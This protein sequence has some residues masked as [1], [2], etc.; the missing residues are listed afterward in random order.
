MARQKCHFPYEII[1]VDDDS[2]DKTVER[3]LAFVENAAL[4][5][6]SVRVLRMDK[7]GPAKAR[8]LGLYYSRGEYVLFIDADCEANP[9]WINVFIRE[10][11]KERVAGVGGP[12]KARNG[13]SK[14]ADYVDLELNYRHLRMMR[15]QVDFVRT[16]NACFRRDILIGIGGFDE[17]FTSA[18]AEDSDLCFRILRRGHRLH[19]NANAWVWHYHPCSV[20]GY[21]K[22]QVSRGVW[23]VLLYL[24]NPEWTRGDSYAGLETLAQPAV[25]TITFLG[26]A[27]TTVM[28]L[29]LAG[30]H[31]LFM[32]LTALMG[33]NSRFLLWIVR[34]RRSISFFAF[35]IGMLVL[36]SLAWTCGGVLGALRFL[37]QILGEH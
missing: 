30:A 25:L 3:A 9:D 29:P 18:N 22:Q 26:M 21:L 2:S 5:D 35:C 19:F 6:V 27:L 1:V 36:R 23:R 32:G 12:Y 17:D 11:E 33:L 10:A 16:A 28:N 20:T 34:T 24:K 31:L 7:G 13:A 8:N 37:P 15:T 14:V 4:K